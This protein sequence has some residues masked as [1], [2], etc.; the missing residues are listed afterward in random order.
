M[1]LS[2]SNYLMFSP[3]KLYRSL[4]E[5]EGREEFNKGSIYILVSAVARIHT[6]N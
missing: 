4:E 5:R 1:Q 3:D 6:G 2:Y